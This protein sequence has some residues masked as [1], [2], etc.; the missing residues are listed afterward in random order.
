MLPTADF[1]HSHWR[2]GAGIV[3]C[4]GEVE[5]EEEEAPP[6]SSR[7][8]TIVREEDMS[9]SGLIL[10][11][12]IVPGT[13]IPLF[14]TGNGRRAQWQPAATRRVM[15]AIPNVH[16]QYGPADREEEAC[17]PPGTKNIRPGGSRTSIIANKNV[18]FFGRLHHLSHLFSSQWNDLKVVGTLTETSSSG[19]TRVSHDGAFVC[20]VSIMLAQFFVWTNFLEHHHDCEWRFLACASHFVLR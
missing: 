4:G 15:R 11:T 5:E 17:L 1:L 10:C 19:Q 2:G 12:S 20:F 13:P 14:S 7:A 6:P 9:R 3:C 18:T 8:Q 16:Q